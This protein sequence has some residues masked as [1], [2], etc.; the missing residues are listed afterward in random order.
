MKQIILILALL[1]SLSGCA[2]LPDTASDDASTAYSA[3]PT[4][5]T[6]TFTFDFSDPHALENTVV[7]RDANRCR[8][9]LTHVEAD[10]PNRYT[11]RFAADAAQTMDGRILL[12]GSV[13]HTQPNGSTSFLH[14]TLLVEPADAFLVY[15]AMQTS[16]L[17][18][19]GNEFAIGLHIN[20]PD[21]LVSSG[22]H[23]AEI[24]LSDLPQLLL[25]S[26]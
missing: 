9:R 4:A 6:C 20:D 16:E 13:P 1:L 19:A 15:F 11:L 18:A 23:T 25:P 3:V 22:I 12:S 8:I 5:E 26:P 21:S 7:Y 10:T 14:A 17:T 2:F 24:T